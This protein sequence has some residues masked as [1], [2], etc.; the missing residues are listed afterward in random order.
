M[1]ER[2]FKKERRPRRVFL[3][4]CEGE[5]EKTYAEALRHFFR[6]PVTIKTKVSGNAINARLINQYLK[7]LNL[8]K[9][10]DYTVF[11]IYDCDV[12]CIIDK[13][14]RLPGEKILT[15]PCFELWYM[16][17]S[18]DHAR[19]VQS[20]TVVKS[21]VES[22]SVWDRYA[23]GRL[24]PEQTDYLMAHRHEA[25]ARAKRLSWPGNPSSNVYALIEALET[26]QKN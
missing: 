10:D 16:L 5:T 3:V 2:R 11:Y 8:T 15:N 18:R 21:L 1:R 25:S 7:E 23:K 13:L 20:D 26:A 6:V 12:E 17:H 9:D 19:V 24:S 22:H 14:H 4:V